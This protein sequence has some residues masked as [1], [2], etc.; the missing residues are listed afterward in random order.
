MKKRKKYVPLKLV[1]VLSI[2][3]TILIPSIVGLT[4]TSAQEEPLK[5]STEMNLENLGVG[6][7]IILTIDDE[8]EIGDI[9]TERNSSLPQ[10]SLDSSYEKQLDEAAVKRQWK[11]TIPEGLSFD[12][13]AE[14]NLILGEDP[15]AEV[16][17]FTYDEETK[18]LLIEVE[19]DTKQST[20]LL[21]I[22]EE[23][24]YELAISDA[25]LP[26]TSNT[27]EFSVKGK[28]DPADFIANAVDSEEESTS[29]ESQAT[30]ENLTPFS[31][32]SITPQEDGLDVG[33]TSIRNEL[34]NIT[35]GGVLIDGDPFATTNLPYVEQGDVLKHYM[36][37]G[38]AYAFSQYISY[39]ELDFNADIYEQSSALNNVYVAITTDSASAPRWTSSRYTIS[40]NSARVDIN[41]NFNAREVMDINIQVKLLDKITNPSFYPGVRFGMDGRIYTPN[42]TGWGFGWLPQRMYQF[43]PEQIQP[44]V[45]NT[46]SS[47]GSALNTTSTAKPSNASEYLSA[48]DTA[49]FVVTSTVANA[50]GAT[51]GVPANTIV[52]TGKVDPTIFTIPSSFSPTVRIGSTNVTATSTIDASGN[53]RVALPASQTLSNTQTL[54]I[55]FSLT[56]S[57]S[58]S[59]DVRTSLVSNITMNSRNGVAASATQATTQFW[60]SATPPA[61][62]TATLNNTVSSDGVAL[63]LTNGTLPTDSTKYLSPGDTADFQ[64]TVTVDNGMTG[65]SGLPVNTIVYTAQVSPTIFNVAGGISNANV[66]ATI[67]G[68]TAMI[69]NHSS[70]SSSGLLTIVFVTTGYL[71]VTLTE[72]QTLTINFS[73]PTRTDNAN[74]VRTTFYST[75]T[76]LD[77]NNQAVNAEKIIQFWYSGDT[78]STTINPVSD[79]NTDIDA[80]GNA[81]TD[82]TGMTISGSTGIPNGY[83]L[84]ENNGSPIDAKRIPNTSPYI[85]YTLQADANGDFSYDVVANN[86]TLVA[87][88]TLNAVGFNSDLTQQSE[89]STV[90][91]DRTA[92]TGT[93][94][95]VT[96]GP[97]DAKPTDFRAFIDTATLADTN[98]TVSASNISVT[99][100][101]GNDA[102]NNWIANNGTK[103]AAGTYPF[104]VYLADPT[105]NRRLVDVELEITE[106]AATSVTVRFMNEWDST[107]DLETAIT[108]QGTVG[109]TIN[110]QQ[111]VD[112]RV[113]SGFLAR[114]GWTLV[115]TPT[116]DTSFTFADTNADLVYTFQ[117][118]TSIAVN[119]LEST[120]NNQLTP[121]VS[122][123]TINGYVGQTISLRAQAQNVIDTII[124]S[125]YALDTN[126]LPAGDATF[127]FID[128]VPNTAQTYYFIQG[129]YLK[130]APAVIDFGLQNTMNYG[131]MTVTDFDYGNTPLVVT[132]NRSANNYWRLTA[133]LT[134]V[135]TS[136]ISS[137]ML[138]N[139]LW[140]KNDGGETQMQLNVPVQIL[141][142]NQT[143]ATDY[144]VSN[145]EWIAKDNGFI[146][147]LN[148][149]DYRELA[150]YNASI[151]YT[152][153]DAP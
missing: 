119:F 137:Q 33:I 121:P 97:N 43:S 79:N 7:G 3:L 24:K 99:Y 53:I 35:Q 109:E 4:Q 5:I 19:G 42:G 93:A 96:V 34:F 9:I 72:G 6:Y 69:A 113:T 51:A 87:S 38:N 25:N 108:I 147:R 50:T 15:E 37:V 115:N 62:V 68:A 78:L 73:L 100:A 152:L 21:T 31:M 111:N 11:I 141:E 125:G 40:G 27:I 148:S 67:D 80:L 106:P 146:F 94:Q 85:Y 128:A 41:Q 139:A 58:R 153:T 57:T 149:S 92:P 88:Q 136:E 75:A 116:G 122:P 131:E 112:Y 135:F 105:G 95:K 76:M 66:T 47:N 132:D 13:E 86:V 23:R 8:R 39:I 133:T 114:L 55:S 110:I 82:V 81:I 84:L 49:D 20:L 32:D 2:L 151:R 126:N 91:V 70:L 127:K 90:I 17:V 48:G 36:T 10:P 129:L 101:S 56:S 26:V 61:T 120:T 118:E 138:P 30:S 144:D 145:A 54:T 46:V 104:Q 64:S 143:N 98:P 63:D 44:T 14:K 123:V 71:S 28:V 18:E 102:V 60:Y 83:V 12:E 103:P 29:G 52:Y 107:Q 124:A 65:T 89:S 117:K 1:A 74:D 130:S 142:N 134:Q 150:N 45:S 59:T 22:D 77:A 140:Y 16:P